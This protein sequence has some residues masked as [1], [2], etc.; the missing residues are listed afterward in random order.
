MSE[1]TGLEFSFTTM[2]REVDDFVKLAGGFVHRDSTPALVDWKKQL[3]SFQESDRSTTTWEIPTSAPVRT[4]LS[5]GKYEYGKGSG[6]KVYGTLSSIW[7]LEK[8]QPE[9]KKSRSLPKSFRVNGKASTKVSIHREGKEADGPLLVWTIDVGD[10]QSPGVHFHAQ[11]GCLHQNTK[12]PVPRVP[13]LLCTPLDG[14]DFLLGELFQEDWLCR[15]SSSRPE[16]KSWGNSQK[17]RLT[18][19]LG[20]FQSTMET[21]RATPWMEIKARKPPRKLFVDGPG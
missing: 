18:K 1:Y 15:T 10:Q 2:L 13:L 5:V 9:G 16:V 12:F 3:I 21:A 7:A 14:L 6:L 19:V 20:W 11:F 8:E 4:E 17:R